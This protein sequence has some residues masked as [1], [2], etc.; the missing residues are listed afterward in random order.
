MLSPDASIAAYKF[1][2]VKGLTNSWAFDL[3]SA[4]RSMGLIDGSYAQVAELL[5]VMLTASRDG[6][7]SLQAVQGMVVRLQA[8][9]DQLHLGL[10]YDREHTRRFVYDVLATQAVLKRSGFHSLADDLPSIA[11]SFADPGKRSAWFEVLSA[12]GMNPSELQTAVEAGD[13][14]RGFENISKALNILITGVGREGESQA[15]ARLKELQILN[16]SQAQAVGSLGGRA[17]RP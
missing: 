16:E 4:T 12:A 10:R 2:R 3:F 7:G 5:G 9:I 1:V 17:I 11:G 8:P 15:L 13:F 6:T 14:A